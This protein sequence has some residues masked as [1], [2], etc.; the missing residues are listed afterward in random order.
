M[1]G[2]TFMGS[3]SGGEE[4]TGTVS[5]GEAISM[6]KTSPLAETATAWVQFNLPKIMLTSC[7]DCPHPKDTSTELGVKHPG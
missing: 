5:Q 6:M 2:K 1:I 7:W 4:S 3:S